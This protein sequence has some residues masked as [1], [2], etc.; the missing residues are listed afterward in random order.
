MIFCLVF[1]I[2]FSSSERILLLIS[3]CVSRF[4]RDFFGFVVFFYVINILISSIVLVMLLGSV[5]VQY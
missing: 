1:L 3:R 2:A 5:L 4:K